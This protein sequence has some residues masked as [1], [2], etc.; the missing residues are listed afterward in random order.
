MTALLSVDS[1]LVFMGSDNRIGISVHRYHAAVNGGIPV[2]AVS[3]DG[4]RR[5]AYFFTA[6]ANN[7]VRVQ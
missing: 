7:I 4:S 5:A 2:F 6:P 3:C 1:I